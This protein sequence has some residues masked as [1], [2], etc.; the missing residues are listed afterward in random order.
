MYALCELSILPCLSSKK[1]SRLAYNTGSIAH[2]KTSDVLAGLAEIFDKM[3]E[4]EKAAQM[5]KV[6]L[7]AA[8]TDR[9]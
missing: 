8:Q 5:K 2:G 1:V 6:S 4:K 9:L 3:P 7:V